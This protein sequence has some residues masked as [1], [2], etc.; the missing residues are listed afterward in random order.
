RI[1]RAVAAELGDLPDAVR[2]KNQIGKPGR[3]K[4]KKQV[5]EL[6]DQARQVI[7]FRIPDHVIV[8]DDWAMVHAL[9]YFLQPRLDGLIQADGEGIYDGSGKLLVS[10]E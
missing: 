1:E 10:L 2:F 5:V 3:S 9:M 7:A 8:E 6:L 4:A